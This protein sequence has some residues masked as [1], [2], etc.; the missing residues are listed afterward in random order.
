MSNVLR[1]TKQTFTIAVA[2]A[3]I[4]WSIGASVLVAPLIAQAAVTPLAD[5]PDGSLIKGAT[6]PAVYYY[7]GAERFVFPN[8]QT[9]KTWYADFSS[10]KAISMADLG[11]I[12]LGDNVVYR[13]GTRLVKIDTMPNVYAVGDNGA[14]R[15]DA[16]GGAVISIAD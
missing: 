9:F 7:D 8:Q 10:V 1:V 5:V 2:A 16:G 14:Q 13:P 6:H 4:L 15:I 3:T 11:T 12:P